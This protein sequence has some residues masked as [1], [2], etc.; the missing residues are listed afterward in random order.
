MKLVIKLID[1]VIA[2]QLLFT[3]RKLYFAYRL[4]HLHPIPTHA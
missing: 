2:I 1:E 4:K 3:K